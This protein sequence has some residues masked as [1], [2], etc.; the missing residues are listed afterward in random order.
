LNTLSIQHPRASNIPRKTSIKILSCIED[1]FEDAALNPEG[2]KIAFIIRHEALLLASELSWQSSNVA[3]GAQN[4][5][6]NEKIIEST[7]NKEVE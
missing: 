4:V 7:W 5:W 6:R 2:I 1:A 3:R